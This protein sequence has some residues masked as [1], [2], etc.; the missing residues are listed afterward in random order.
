MT[1][2]AEAGRHTEGE[3]RQWHVMHF[4]YVIE[5]ETTLQYSSPSASSVQVPT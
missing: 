3:V 1:A 2:E 4:A 5:P